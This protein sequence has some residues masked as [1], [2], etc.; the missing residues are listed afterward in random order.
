[1][2]LLTYNGVSL[3]YPLATSFSQEGVGDDLSDTDWCYTKFD[4]TV[5]CLINKAYL[6]LLA[7]QL[8][9]LGGNGQAGLSPADI[10]SVIR[11]KLLQRRRAFSYTFNGRE[12]IPQPQTGNQGS[13]DAKNGPVPQFCNIFD[14]NNTTWMLQYRIVA[15]YWEN[16]LID[17]AGTPVVTNQPGQ[18]AVWHRWSETEELDDCLMITRT[19]NGKY[20][21]RSDNAKGLGVDAV[22]GDLVT[23]AVPAGFTR[24]SSSYTVDP[25]GLALAYTIVDKQQ[26][27]M[28]PKPAYVASGNW[29]VNFGPAMNWS[30]R[31]GTVTVRLKGA[32]NVSQDDL[33]DAISKICM[34]KIIANSIL[35]GLPPIANPNAPLHPETA[36][37]GTIILSATFSSNMYEN[38]VEGSVTARLQG[39]AA[40]VAGMMT[41]ANL[42]F[43]FTPLSDGDNAGGAKTY[44]PDYSAVYGNPGGTG[45]LLQAAK[46]YDPSL[47]NAALGPDFNLRTG[48]QVGQAGTNKE[49]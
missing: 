47:G 44:Q 2:S 21:I 42:S 24:K 48:T 17:A 7:T 20:A 12:V 27:K 19:R 33:L 25:S 15:H 45:I 37:P 6:S 40:R 1:M 14:L 49:A 8:Q 43:N 29:T 28:P 5:T 26:Y 3:P 39:D 16:N 23:L 11:S 22:R 10:M 41:G 31:V 32:I 34:N 35:N 46:Y 9:L 13:V 38:I 36:A 18:T 4:I 30:T